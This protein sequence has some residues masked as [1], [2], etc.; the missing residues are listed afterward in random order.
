LQNNTKETQF[1]ILKTQLSNL[2]SI[3]KDK[4]LLGK[5]K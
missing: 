2:T 1:K 5:N 4:I 3:R